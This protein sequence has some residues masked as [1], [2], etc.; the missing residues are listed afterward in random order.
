MAARQDKGHGG[1]ARS[2]TVQGLAQSGGQFPG[3]I[4]IEQVEELN[5]EPGGRFAA[6]EGRLKEG[7]A[8]RDHRGQTTGG[9]GAQGLAFLL[10]Q[11]V[12]VRGV[13][14]E[15]MPVIASGG[16]K[17]FRSSRRAGGRVVGEATSVKAR[18]KAR[19]GTE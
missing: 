1:K 3:T 15:L 17:R 7:W 18:P 2:V 12:A 11:G 16:G 9:G 6:L 4:V 5:G 14:D 19:G 13:F 10:Q 8:F